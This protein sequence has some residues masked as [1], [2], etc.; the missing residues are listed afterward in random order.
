MNLSIDTT[1]NVL[2]VPPIATSLIE[3]STMYISIRLA[4]LPK[5]AVIETII[6]LVYLVIHSQLRSINK[7]VQLRQT[8]QFA[9]ILST[10]RIRI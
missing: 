3:V 10:K 5:K 9:T 7:Q 8:Q 4:Y 1:T 2:F 6:A